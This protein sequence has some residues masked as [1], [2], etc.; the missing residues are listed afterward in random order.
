MSDVKIHDVINSMIEFERIPCGS[1]PR[2]PH[3]PL[4]L[5][6]TFYD[7]VKTHRP[8]W[9]DA[10]SRCTRCSKMGVPIVRTS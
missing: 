4:I 5:S 2:K 1:D 8:E 7:V 10:L 9:I 6:G 3:I